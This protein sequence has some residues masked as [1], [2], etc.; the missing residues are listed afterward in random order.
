MCQLSAPFL[1][2]LVLILNRK[3]Y[4]QFKHGVCRLKHEILFIGLFCFVLIMENK[5][6]TADTKQKRRK[7]LR[8][9][10]NK[11]KGAF[12]STDRRHSSSPGIQSRRKGIS[13]KKQQQQKWTNAKQNKMQFKLGGNTIDPLNLMGLIDKD[14]Y[15]SP[16]VDSPLS[17]RGHRFE[18]G[19]VR[20]VDFT[21]PLKLNNLEDDVLNIKAHAHRKRK[22]R[23]RRHTLTENDIVDLEADKNLGEDDGKCLVIFFF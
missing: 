8:G 14:G 17:D 22:K 19:D 9:T 5:I 23:K 16:R 1:Y 21:D 7:S 4:V 11:D 3:F 20:P 13:K 18:P 12:K 2:S 10:P 15:S 6:E